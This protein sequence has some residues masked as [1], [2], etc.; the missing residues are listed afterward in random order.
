LAEATDDEFLCVEMHRLTLANLSY[1]SGMQ[2]GHYG[3]EA[4]EVDAPAVWPIT[5]NPIKKGAMAVIQQM[6]S[7]EAAMTVRDEALTHQR[8]RPRFDVAP[9]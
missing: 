3:V 1:A 8:D 7:E 6:L 4:E 9:E 2:H 5:L